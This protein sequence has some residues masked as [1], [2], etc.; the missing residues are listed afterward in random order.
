MLQTKTILNALPNSLETIDLKNAGKK[1]QGKVRDFYIQKSSR[2][3]ITTDRQS[4]FDVNLGVIPFKGAVLN[5]LAAFWFSKTKHIISN[6]IIAL[7]DPN[8]TLA[9]NLIPIPI[10]MIVRGY[11]SG[12]TKTSIWYSYQKGERK[13]Y[14]ITFPNN[15]KKNDKL[16]TPV[17]TP[18][19]HGG[20]KD[21]HDERL[22]KKE[23]LDR[24]LID[25]KT[26]EHMEKASLALFMFGSTLAE[27]KG[28]ILVDTKYEFGL[29]EKGKL[30]LMDEMHTPDSSR[31][32]IK[33]T[34]KDRF[35]TGQEPENFDKEFLRLW[36]K[37]QG[38]TGDGTP[39][40]MTPILIQQ[41]SKRYK[42]IFQ[43][44]TG[45]K[46]S[47]PKKPIMQRIKKNIKTYFSKKHLA[48]L[49]SNGGVGTNLQAIIDAIEQKKLNA[50]IAIV[51]SD[52][53][54]AYGLERAKK[55]NIARTISH[56]KEDLLNILQEYDIDY[57]C[58]AGW[59][60]FIAQDVMD[61]YKNR[62]LNL[63]PGLI[64]N[65]I[66]GMVKNPDGTAGLWNRKKLQ[67]NALQNF[68]E[69]NATYAGSSI[70]FL[71]AEVDFGKILGRCFEKIHPG[72]TIDSLYTRLKK[73]ENKLY[74]DVLKK[75]PK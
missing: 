7:P 9:K 38:Y 6:H 51:I 49:I 64:P 60:Q 34:Y 63:H 58:L 10:E 50:A 68:L 4:A 54:D 24:K 52:N 23:I 57:I 70:H 75:L 17:I 62:I 19:T 15:L 31:F 33:K 71:S 45:E 42:E 69:N 3:I 48:V 40:K 21:G 29:D 28:L 73:K 41:V 32:W 5:L 61:T 56:I 47:I 65:T 2:I 59:K 16:P 25:K 37:K 30:T 20:G 22:T 39:P 53:D 8:V 18:T 43:K 13:I 44:I 11:M 1:L 12:V 46:L 27:K 74:V 67:N 72:D 66:T 36:Y 55:H 26:Y 35:R 14:G